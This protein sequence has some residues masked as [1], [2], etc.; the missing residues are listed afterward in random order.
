MLISRLV[1]SVL[2]PALLSRGLLAVALP[3]QRA[4]PDP[5]T[6]IAGLLLVDPA[7][8]IA[9]QKSFKFDERLRKNVMSVV[10][11]VFDFFSFE[12]F[13]LNSPPPF[14]ESTKDIRAEIA[15][16]SSTRYATDYDFN[17]DLYD[18]TNQLND[19]HT[20]WT[21]LCYMTYSNILPTPI[22]LLDKGVFVAPDVDVLFGPPGGN[23]SSYF[24]AKGFDWRRFA[25]A[26]VLKIGGV[27]ARDYI[28]TVARTASGNFLDH[29]IRVN[30]VVS[31]YQMP[32]GNFSQRLGDLAS[33]PVLRQTS[34]QFTLIPVDSPSGSPECIDVPFVAVLNGLPFEDGPSYWENNCAPTNTTNGVDGR[35]ADATSR[36]VI[37]AGLLNPTA[38]SDPDLPS[39]FLPTAPES[40]GS[41]SIMKTFILPGNKTGVM[42]IG[43]FEG[44]SDQFPVDVAAAAKKFK[45]SGVKNILIDVTDNGGGSV[46]L[47]LF[48]HQFLAGSKIGLPG[49][50]ST[51]RANPLAQKIVKANIA[52]G[53]NSTFYSP[54]TWLFLNGTKM[55]IDFDYNDPSLPYVINGRQD[56]TSQRF[57]DSCPDPPVAVPADPPFDLKYLFLVGNGFCASTCALFT[58]LMYERHQTKIV[59]FGGHPDIP[60]EYKGMAGNQ[61]LSFPLLDTE[62]KTAG[63]KDDPLAPPDLLVNADMRHNW[64]SAYSFKN[65]DLPIAYVSEPSQFRFPYTA[66]TYNNPQKLW[67]FVLVSLSPVHFHLITS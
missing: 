53:L 48:L 28:D 33:S 21:P 19:G 63:L 27:P 2:L 42:F 15:R 16:I 13:Y 58:T 52:Q 9:C 43:T 4:T 7:D 25:G 3:T 60:I 51:S 61:V 24:K 29:N 20:G 11:R 30:S 37:H 17:M 46:C 22:V 1:S 23:F 59:T 44:D 32:S 41:N 65:E 47:G 57:R 36:R 40:D 49:F 62:I 56:P 64:R 5:C 18:F 50:Q 31:S 6:K 54:N 34:L 39:P 12:D 10:S 55:P 35:T 66:E 14:Q 8:A 45:A 26:Q 38:G 67:S